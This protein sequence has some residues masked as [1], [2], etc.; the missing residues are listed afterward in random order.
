MSM[1]SVAMMVRSVRRAADFAGFIAQLGAAALLSRL[2]W[3]VAVTFC[4]DAKKKCVVA[5][6]TD[7]ALILGG[8]IHKRR[9][10][11]EA[12]PPA[13]GGVLARLL[14]LCD[15]AGVHLY[16]WGYADKQFFG[17]SFSDFAK[18]SRLETGL[19][20]V[21][22]RYN[23]REFSYVVDS[24]APYF[25]GRGPTDLENLLSTTPSGAWKRNSQATQFIKS[26]AGSDFQ[27][28]AEVNRDL[29]IAIG[30]RDVVVVGQCEG[31]A[32]WIE[33]DSMVSDNVN[34]VE[35]AAKLFSGAEI[36][37]KPHPFNRTNQ[38]D[39]AVV[40]ERGLARVV[41]PEISFAQIA[42]R[43]PI[44]VVNTS[45][46]GL[47]AAL[48]GCQVHTFG[49]SYYSHWGFTKDRTI[50]PRRSNRL[51]AEDVFYV[52][53]FNY[54]RYGQRAPLKRLNA[55]QVTKQPA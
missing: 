43:R 53:V 41:S 26:I 44:V 24:K 1:P 31:D 6:E 52:M 27:K 37:Y 9:S 22:A 48:R 40:E 17:F 32:A 4:V 50:C 33:T 5:L 54:C 46:A 39:S 34:L 13:F 42:A 51:T 8:R 29:D 23:A 55:E 12:L 16:V 14:G 2:G 25:D 20:G 36:Y 35:E 11:S 45:G 21:G 15:A 7:N 30:D 47:E 49:T 18:T 3:K 38:R 19:F 10:A 28:Y